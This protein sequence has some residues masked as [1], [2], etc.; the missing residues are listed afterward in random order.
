MQVQYEPA[1]ITIKGTR[2]GIA[3]AEAVL[4]TNLM[5]V[6]RTQTYRNAV[7]IKYLKST[8]RKLFRPIES[9]KRCVIKLDKEPLPQKRTS[10]HTDIDNSLETMSCVLPSG[11]KISIRDGA[12]FD[13]DVDVM[14][15]TTN[16]DLKL[17]GGLGKAIA[18]K[19][20]CHTVV[21]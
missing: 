7:W 16:K 11:Q 8:E 12:I 20:M 1:A 18:D 13:L 5:C 15:C 19:G 6:K 4:N 17:V 14:I 2:D 21:L 9:A 3:H 10:V